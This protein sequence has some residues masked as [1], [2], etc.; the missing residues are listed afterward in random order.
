[1]TWRVD[2]RQLAACLALGGIAPAPGS[3]LPALPPT[4]DPHAALA[5]GALVRANGRLDPALERALRAAAAPT[6]ALALTIADGRAPGYRDAMIAVREE[7]EAAYL[8]AT[9]EGWTVK[10]LDAAGARFRLAAVAGAYEGASLDPYEAVGPL[11]A[12]TIVALAGACDV[13]QE[14]QLRSRLARRPRPRPALDARAV[15]AKV[16]E[17]FARGDARWA[18][19]ALRFVAP[20]DLRPHARRVP[21]GLTA[22][23][24]A[25]VLDD[26]GFSEKGA[27]I[28]D[29]VDLRG[30]VGVTAV[31]PEGSAQRVRDRLSLLRT[32]ARLHALRWDARGRAT[33]EGLD[34]GGA[35]SLVASLL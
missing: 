2:D 20:V 3:L 5:G 8:D 12:A 11:D 32:D 1:M 35:R 28:A 17:G 27:P 15:Q 26:A 14:A 19:T 9:E 16:E 29:L 6:R 22:L 23:R 31:A 25:G 30:S 34:A 7:G 18:T 24:A 21:D 13:L 33:I 10:A 4:P